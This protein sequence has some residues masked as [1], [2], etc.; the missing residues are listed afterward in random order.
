MNTTQ[1]RL[2]A[3]APDA[4]R[5]RLRERTRRLLLYLNWQRAAALL[6]AAGALWRVVRYAMGF[7]IW[8]DEAFI[9]VDLI[10]RDYAGMLRPLSYGQIVPL[11]FMWAEL[12]ISRAL[13]FSEH[14]L[15]LLPFVA[16]LAGLALFAWLATRV[17]PRRAALVALGIFA[18]SYYPIR[19]SCE[20]KPY[21]TDLLTSLVLL[22]LI[23]QVHTNPR[24]VAW[25]V[26]LTVCAGVA[27]WCSYPSVF[28]TGSGLVLLAWRIL[29]ERPARVVVGAWVLAATVAGGSF[30]AMYLL[31]GHP[32]A[33]YG[34][35]LTEI[36]MWSRTFPPL[37]EP[38]KLLG[39]FLRMHTG[40]MLAY[41]HGGDK[42]AST[43]T[44]VFVV[45]GAVSLW[46]RRRDLVLLLLIPLGLTFIAAALHKYP[47]G[48][49]ARTSLYMA[50]S[51]CL[52]AGAG[53]MSVVRRLLAGQHRLLCVRVVV[54]LLAVFAACGAGLDAVRPYKSEAVYRSRLAVQT[55]CDRTGPADLWV[56]F[57]SPEPVSYAPYLGDWRGVGGQF[58][59][60]VLRFAP[61]QVLWAPPPQTIEPAAPQG[62]V[63]VLSYRGYKVPFPD[64]LLKSYLEELTGR[65]GTP[66]H[67]RFV[68]KTRG[69]Q[70]E[71]LDLYVF[72][73]NAPPSPQG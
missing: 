62:R 33:V 6:L 45:I 31:Y 10:R 18:A 29:R 49:S 19:H 1:M 11:F 25:W 50:P 40:Y 38:L 28:I 71:A 54:V 73:P 4:S 56:V 46:S 63:F 64:D 23:W 42:G 43:A 26:V 22:A 36:P 69:D 35:R 39:W 61:V 67:E 44:A 12:G 60:D 9:G 58:V 32:Q 20:L 47:Y 48:G 65:L 5:L 68:I 3:R 57:N 72:G 24:R 51:F 37:G 2:I 13:G 70:I 52:L 27:P 55:V 8:G 30:A 66:T 15:R 7:P 14:A 53:L 34:S 17:L 21:A 59:F 16:G 41:P